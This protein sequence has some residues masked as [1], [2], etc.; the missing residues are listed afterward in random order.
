MTRWTLLGSFGGTRT[1]LVHY[2]AAHLIQLPHSMHL[3]KRGPPRLTAKH[4]APVNVID[5]AVSSG[6]VKAN[7][8]QLEHAGDFGIFWER[9]CGAGMGQPFASV[10]FLRWC[11]QLFA[12]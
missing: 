6:V 12:S 9:A 3:E 5:N 1:T 8:R 2:S 7:S 4:A 11:K 10:A